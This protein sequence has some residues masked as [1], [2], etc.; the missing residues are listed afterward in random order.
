MKPTLRIK[1][2]LTDGTVIE[3]EEELDVVQAMM[4]SVQKDG[5]RHGARFYPTDAI[6]TIEILPPPEQPAFSDN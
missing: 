3:L 1:I 2:T 4:E 6:H 5:C